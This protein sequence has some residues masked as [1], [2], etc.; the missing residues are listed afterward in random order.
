MFCALLLHRILQCAAPDSNSHFVYVIEHVQNHGGDSRCERQSPRVRGQSWPHCF[1]KWGRILSPA[2]VHESHECVCVYDVV[3]TLLFLSF[4]LA[5]TPLLFILYLTNQKP[6]GSARGFFLLKATF[7]YCY[8][9]FGGRALGF[10]RDGTDC[11]R[12]FINKAELN[13]DRVFLA[14]CFQLTPVGTVVFSVQATDADNNKI[15]YSIDQTSVSSSLCSDYRSNTH[16]HTQSHLHLC[17]RV[18]GSLMQSISRLSFPTVERWSC[19]NLLT[20]RPKSCWL[21]P[22]TPQ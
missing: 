17:V 18:F 15:I 9:L 16:T 19:P 1:L 8:C 4:S 5:L 6:S 14:L 21:S 12:C 7:P 3:V 2:H 10:C 11:N 20:M 13:W 22:S